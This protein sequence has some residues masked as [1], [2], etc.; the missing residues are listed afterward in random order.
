MSS[1]EFKKYRGFNAR[2]HYDEMSRESIVAQGA[3]FGATDLP[4]S[5]DWRTKAGVVTEVKDQGGCG[6]CWAFS[7]AE[8]VESAVAIATGKPAPVLSPQQLVDCVQNPK[9]CGGSGG[10]EGSTQ[11]IAFNYT[12]PNGLTLESLYPYKGSDGT[13]HKEVPTAGI[14]GQVVLASNNWTQLMTA[15]A[16]VGPVAISVAAEP[17]QFYDFGIFDRDCG[18]DVDHAVQAVGYGEERG[19]GY[20]IVRNSW[21]ASWGE[22]GYIRVARALSDTDVKCKTDTHPSDGFGCKN[23]PKTIQVCGECGI[24]SASSYPTGAYLYGTVNEDMAPTKSIF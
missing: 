1:E 8:T 20:W 24:L 7:T 15:V 18:A 17:W 4:D 19:K 5:V 14:K 9:D 23:G 21:S 12:I 6:S 22:R 11:P 13:C 10:C 2:A 16:E 3:E